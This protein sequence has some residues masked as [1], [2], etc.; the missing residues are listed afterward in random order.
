MSI[1]SIIIAISDYGTLFTN[2]LW[3]SGGGPSNAQDAG[4]THTE[5]PQ[6]AAANH[7]GEEPVTASAKTPVDHEERITGN[8]PTELQEPKQGPKRIEGRTRAYGDIY[9]SEAKASVIT[10]EK[11]RGEGERTNEMIWKGE[12]MDESIK[13]GGVIR[14]EGKDPNTDLGTAKRERAMTTMTT[15]TVAFETPPR[16]G[17]PGHEETKEE[18]SAPPRSSIPQREETKEERRAPPRS[19]FPGQ[20]ERKEE[21][22]EERKIQ[23][24]KPEAYGILETPEAKQT[25][26]TPENS[27]T[28]ARDRCNA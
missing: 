1:S 14:T 16:S 15:M 3:N 25:V 2:Y 7:V 21:R 27:S 8:A 11:W 10:L 23:G 4:K 9:M 18:R 17:F 19:S 13:T 24:G 6:E 20:E 12:G 26:M 5:P 22:R 28:Y